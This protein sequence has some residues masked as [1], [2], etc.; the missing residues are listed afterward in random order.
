MKVFV[1]ADNCN[2]DSRKIIL[3]ACTRKN[4]EVELVANKNIERLFLLGY[5]EN[6]LL[7]VCNLRSLALVFLFCDRIGIGKSRQIVGIL[8]DRIVG[9]SVD[10][11][12]L[13]PRGRIINIFD[14]VFA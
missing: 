3:K 9:D 13:L 5:G 8:Q 10:G 7:N 12:D 2:K 6:V 1:D 11:R 14:S 4:I